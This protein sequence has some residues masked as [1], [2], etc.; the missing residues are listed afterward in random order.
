MARIPYASPEDV[1]N[2][3]LIERVKAQRGEVLHLY[4]MLLHSEE[5]TDGWL[6]LFTAVRQKGT[7]PGDL[8]ELVIM[9]VALI[10][11]APYEAQQHR[12]IALKEGLT[13]AQVDELADWQNSSVYTPK[14]RAILAYC[15]QM[16]RKVHVDDAVFAEVKQYLDNKLMLEL[17]VTIAGYNMVSR[18]LEALHIDAKDDRGG[19]VE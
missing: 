10:N 6:Q 3:A 8:R 18:V 19:W 16:T 9:Q 12:P 15:D 1:K 5:I 4:A 11:G 17:T 13:E 2:D 7:L 14:H